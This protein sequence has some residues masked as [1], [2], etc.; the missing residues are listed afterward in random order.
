MEQKKIHPI[1]Y[2]ITKLEMGGAQKVCLSLF[3]KFSTD[4]KTAWLI[5]GSEGHLV[6]EIKHHK[7]VI[8]LPSLKREIVWKD[9]AA[10][11]HIFCEI[12]KLKA[13]HPNLIVHTHSTK[14]GYLGRWAAWCVGIK[15]IIHTVHGFGFHDHQSKIGYTIAYLLERLTNIITTR[16]ICVSS[17]D[18]KIGLKKFPHFKK[19]YSLIRAAVDDL[20]LIPAKKEFTFDGSCTF[21]TIACFKPQKNLFD[22]LEAFKQVH[23]YQPQTKLEIIGDGTQRPL[24]ERWIQK[25]HLT[26]AITLHGWQENPAIFMHNWDCFVLSSLW[27]GL[28]CAAVEARFLKIPVIS[29]NIG[30]LTDIIEHGKNGYLC[31]VKNKA[32]LAHY[33]TLVAQNNYVRHALGS[34]EQDLNAFTQ[35]TMLNLHQDLYCQSKK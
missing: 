30:G 9:F 25:H 29:Y 33:M 18:I 35:A 21:G 14:A 8:L 12:K 31:Q 24:I 27:E 11:W 28:P 34:Y 13:Q 19:K 20:Q 5:S 1:L 6:E 4:S 15:T 2:I 26:S 10:F 32:L 16:Y 22:L 3:K 7:N 17:A 23:F